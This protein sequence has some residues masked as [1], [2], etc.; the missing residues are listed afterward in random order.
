MLNRL[1]LGLAV[2]A[3]G[4]LAGAFAYTVASMVPTFHAVPMDV[5]LRFRTQ[6]MVT[7]GIFMQA[8][9]ATS[10]ISSFWLAITLRGSDRWYAT[11]AG[12]M[13]LTS[14]LVTRFGNVPINGKIKTWSAAALPPDHADLLRRWEIFHDVRT[15]AGVLAFLLLILVVVRR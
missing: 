14:L 13:A 5:H 15:G 12:V 7:N 6:L 10:L 4:L 8:V 9:M 1:A 11:G 2:L 3:T